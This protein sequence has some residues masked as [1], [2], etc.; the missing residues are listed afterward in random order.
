MIMDGGGAPLPP[1]QPGEVCVRGPQVMQGYHN[2]PAATDD[3]LVDGWLHTSRSAPPTRSHRQSGV[4]EMAIFLA[5]KR[6]TTG[7]I[8]A[9]LAELYG[10]EVA[11]GRDRRENDGSPG[12]LRVWFGH[13]GFCGR[14]DERIRTGD[15]L[16]LRP[17]W[18]PPWKTATSEVSLSPAT[19]RFPGRRW[20]HGPR[21]DPSRPAHPAT[22]PPCPPQHRPSDPG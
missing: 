15:P 5:A 18:L 4:D 19:C 1:G 3:V 7:E 12:D 22:V 8:S 16:I 13:R 11:H 14:R 9:Y 20:C 2:R 21:V 6:M 17:R 10:I